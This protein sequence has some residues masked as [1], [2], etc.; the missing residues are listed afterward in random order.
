MVSRTST[1]RR[2]PRG[3]AAMRRRGDRDGDV[4]MDSIAVKGRSKIGKAA[5][6]GPAATRATRSGGKDIL[7]T[8][9]RREL[10][11]KAASGDVSMRE[12]RAPSSAVVLKI[13]GWTKSKAAENSDGGRKSLTQWLEKKAGMRLGRKDVR[14][15]KTK[16]DGDTLLITVPSVD[17]K[18]YQRMDGYEW[19]G[20]KLS[21]KREGEA[22]E[23]KKD[24]QTEDVKAML[25]GVLERRWNPDTKVLDLTALGQDPDLKASNMFDKSSTTSKFFPALMRVLEMSFDKQQERDE[26]V[27][28]VTLANNALENLDIVKDLSR[29]LPS[30]QNLDLSNNNFANMAAL[31]LWRRRFKKLQN[32][33]LTGNP[34]EQNEP[35]FATE[36]IKWYP[37]LMFLNGIQVRTEEDV[38]NQNNITNIP[39]PIRSPQFQDEGQIAETFIRNWFLGFDTDRPQLAQVYYDENSEFSLAVN[40]GAPRDP[41]GK[42][43]TGPQE[44]DQYIKHSR[45]LKKLNHIGARAS[46]LYRGTKPI[47]DLFA[48]LPKTQ[49]PTLEESTKWMIESH[50]QPGIPDPT[51][52]SPSGVDGFFIS[53]HGEYNEPE[54]S[55]Q[56]SMDHAI[57][58]GPGGSM[59]VR[60]VSHTVT[61]RAYGGDQAFLPIVN[62]PPMPA[63]DASVADGLPQ[64]PAGISL[65]IAEQMVA[66]LSKQTNLTPQGSHDCLTQTAWNF[67]AALQAFNNVKASLGPEWFINGVAAA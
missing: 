43:N 48:Q 16:Q 33:I 39:F 50:I 64:L 11:R 15:R 36:I 1:D 4:T 45:N 14:I 62:T 10:I 63:A 51:G 24:S 31:D 37:S 49:H 46:R 9:G 34:L 17:A 26:A 67:D 60:V 30:L 40:T 13:D 3:P 18:A 66:E 56:R 41:S 61:V 57:Y 58:I 8:G 23:E 52:A 65:E 53:I 7:T 2:P 22:G 12:T 19:A 38:K 32:L 28:G 27:T 6:T 42:V 35:N 20:A 47:G 21:I 59:G 29:T 25:R 55:K 44:W 54:T 5:P